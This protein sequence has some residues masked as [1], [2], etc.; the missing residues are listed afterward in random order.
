MLRDTTFDLFLFSLMDGTIGSKNFNDMRDDYLQRRNE[1][2]PPP[3]ESS[4]HHRR[5]RTSSLKKVTCN[6]DSR[7]SAANQECSSTIAKPFLHRQNSFVCLTLV[8]LPCN[9]SSLILRNSNMRLLGI[10]QAPY[11]ECAVDIFNMRERDGVYFLRVPE[12]ATTAHVKRFLSDKFGQVDISHS[13]RVFMDPEDSQEPEAPRMRRA[14]SKML[15][16]R[17]CWRIS[18]RPRIESGDGKISPCSPTRL[19]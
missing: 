4:V 15:L 19:P 11:N 5:S 18:S 9:I 10:S 12:V 6:D 17:I 2:L 8:C 3:K 7:D 1:A 13:I 16:Q 14:S